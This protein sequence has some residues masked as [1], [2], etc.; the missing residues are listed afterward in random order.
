MYYHND[1]TSK[2]NL[3]S[4]LPRRVLFFATKLSTPNLPNDFGLL[5]K[6][7]LLSLPTPFR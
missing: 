7:I 3:Q 5:T 4:H 1:S 2:R 6:V